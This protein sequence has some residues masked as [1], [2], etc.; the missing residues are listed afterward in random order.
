MITYTA[1]YNFN[2]EDI[3][4][5]LPLNTSFDINDDKINKLFYG[6]FRITIITFNSIFF[7]FII[8]IHFSLRI[9]AKFTKY[10]IFYI[11]FH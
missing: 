7:N 1:F 2:I 11:F 9:V 10:I 8:T 3:I 5:T 6:I 4:H